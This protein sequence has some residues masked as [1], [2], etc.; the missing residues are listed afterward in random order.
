MYNDNHGFASVVSVIVTMIFLSLLTLAAYMH[1]DTGEVSITINYKKLQN[2][3]LYLSCL[4]E[5]VLRNVHQ[6]NIILP[7][8]SVENECS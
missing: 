5:A 7:L 1:I 6:E 3:Y 2:R 8:S 4:E